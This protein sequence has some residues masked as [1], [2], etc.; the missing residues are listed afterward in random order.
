[1]VPNESSNNFGNRSQ[2]RGWKVDGDRLKKVEYAPL[3]IHL[4][5]GRPSE[6]RKIGFVPFL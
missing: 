6:P 2:E 4:D 5:Y 3:N 1:M